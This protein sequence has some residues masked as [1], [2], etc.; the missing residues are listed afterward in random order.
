MI[1]RRS[2]LGLLAGGAAAAG[3]GGCR[4][5]TSRASYRFR[6]TIEGGGVTGSGVLQVSAAR[7]LALTAHE[8]PGSVG[9]KGE[10]VVLDLPDGPVFALLTI[11]DGKPLLATRVTLALDPEADSL[12]AGK[13]VQAVRALGRPFA[14]ARAELP[15]RDWPLM[16]RFAD[17]ADPASV[18]RVDP[19]TAGIFSIMLETTRDPV[20]T[21][22]ER[23]LGWLGKYPEPRLDRNYRGS[24][25]PTLSQRLSYGDFRR[26]EK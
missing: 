20:T 1:A 23:R 2:V 24:A 15:R 6:M 13:F 21:G 4:L 9:L 12:D 19:E 7:L 8:H 5:F 10:A 25:N 17:I 11:G 22:I 16:V 18:E 26:G 3:L 14:R